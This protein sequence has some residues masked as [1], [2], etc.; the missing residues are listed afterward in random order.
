MI[1]LKI[2]GEE[3]EMEEIFEFGQERNEFNKSYDLKFY[4]CKNK[5]IRRF[6]LK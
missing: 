5:V 2:D 4:D 6:K 1:K 3:L